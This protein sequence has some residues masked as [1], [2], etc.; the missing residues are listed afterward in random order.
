MSGKRR[1]R[2]KSSIFESR[3]RSGGAALVEGAAAEA[4]ATVDKAQLAELYSEV[5]KLS[6]QNVGAPWRGGGLR[7]AG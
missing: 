4:A 2:R 7:R 1:R 3:R 6:A 5:I